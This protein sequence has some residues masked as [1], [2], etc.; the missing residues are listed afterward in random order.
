[1]PILIVG[2]AYAPGLQADVAKHLC[3]QFIARSQPHL[4]RHFIWSSG[5]PLQLCVL[6]CPNLRSMTPGFLSSAIKQHVRRLSPALTTVLINSYRTEAYLFVD[7]DVIKS[8][9]SFHADV[10]HCHNSN[11]QKA[12]CNCQPGMVCRQCRWYGAYQTRSW[13][14]ILQAYYKEEGDH[15]YRYIRSDWL[16]KQ[17][18]AVYKNR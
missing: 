17:V 16:Q 2:E 4:G 3:T 14:S 10:C 5:S 13:F 9:S 6:L 18:R 7:G 15:L 12:K 8:R 11:N 1:M